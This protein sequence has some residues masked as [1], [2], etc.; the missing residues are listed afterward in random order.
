MLGS[1]R[2]PAREPGDRV[3]RDLDL[4]GD[5]GEQRERDDFSTT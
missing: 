3:R 1:C 4:I 5:E 2:L